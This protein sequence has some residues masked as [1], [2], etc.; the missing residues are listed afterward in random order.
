MK[1]LKNFLY[2]YYK[3]IPTYTFF[4]QIYRKL[5]YISDSFKDRRLKL[6][7]AV[8]EKGN[9]I[10]KIYDYGKITRMRARTFESKEP[11][12]LNWI[13]SFQSDE[14]LLDVGANIGMYSLYA[15]I[16]GYK[17]IAIEPDALN[18]SLLCLNIKIN[19][20]YKKIIPYSIALHNCSKFSKFNV[21]LGEWGGSNNSFDRALDEEMKEFK[22]AYSQVTYGL[23]LDSFIETL[24]S[25]PNHIK[26]DVDGNEFLILKGAQNVL[27]NPSLKSVLIE[28]NVNRKDY[29][30]TLSIFKKEGFKLKSY[31]RNPKKTIYNHIFVR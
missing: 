2:P 7:I 19:K 30:P 27:S 9:Y 3:N 22:P 20:L 31:D 12:T 28:L 1:N 21:N 8:K 11:E 14:I 13:N 24:E 16:K 29:N 5:I 26:I 25:F 4:R 18:F 6:K 15:A 10:F 17:V 23:P